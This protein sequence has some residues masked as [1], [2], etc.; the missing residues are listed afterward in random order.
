MPAELPHSLSVSGATLLQ[1]YPVW[2]PWGYTV[3]TVSIGIEFYQ[4]DYPY[5]HCRDGY[6]NSKGCA[7]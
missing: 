5:D 7:N 1:R 2:P 4:D 3:V 6:S